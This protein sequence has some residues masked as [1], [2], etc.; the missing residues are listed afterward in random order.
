[1]EAL[2]FIELAK[3]V[4][5]EEK[6]PLSP[7]E[8]W[9]IAT[10]KGYDKELRKVGKTPWATIGAQLYVSV[11]DR[12]DTPF[13]RV[14]T[15]PARFHLRQLLSV[16]ELQ[17]LEQTAQ[18]N[19]QNEDKEEKG[20][21]FQERD[22]HSFLA[23]YA[24]LYLRSYTKT[25]QHSRSEKKEYGEWIHPDMVGCYFPLEDWKPEVMEFGSMIGNP[26]IKLFS[27]EIKKKLGFGNLRESF[28]QTVS[29]SSWAHEAYLVAADIAT[30]EDFRSELKRLSNSFGIG[31]IRLN[32]DDPDSSEIV[33]PARTRET[34]D[35]EAMNKLT[36]NSDFREFL[37]RVKNDMANKEIIEEKY[38][39]VLER[40]ELIK[41][42]KKKSPTKT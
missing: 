7:D 37:K 2:T 6:R 27:F 18:D 13:V 23:Y 35:W 32:T 29:N 1:M 41:T 11:R 3:R 16:A 38:D 5:Q 28:F 17:E 14:G 21:Q 40:E 33:F 25:I 36:M 4:V 26:A 22:L 15:R 30:D 9:K 39:K 20:A 12:K 10:S 42:I 34:L 31:V 24:S 19:D 8:I